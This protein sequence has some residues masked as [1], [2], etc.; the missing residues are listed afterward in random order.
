MGL[1]LYSVDSL[2]LIKNDVVVDRVQLAFSESAGK[3]FGAVIV[4]FT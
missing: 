2:G 4:F 1:E 3:A